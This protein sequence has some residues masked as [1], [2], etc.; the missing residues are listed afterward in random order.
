MLIVVTDKADLLL[1]DTEF[2]KNIG[3][4]DRLLYDLSLIHN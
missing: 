3:A 1:L 2:T 4:K